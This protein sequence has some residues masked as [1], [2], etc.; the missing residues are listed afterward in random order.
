[1]KM[2]VVDRIDTAY[3]IADFLSA[4]EDRA[5]VA[6]LAGVPQRA[7]EAYDPVHEFAFA[8]P[9]YDGEVV[10][11]RSEAAA[12]EPIWFGG[13]PVQGTPLPEPLA[14][15]RDRAQDAL[16]T[17]GHTELERLAEAPFT[18]VYVDRYEAGGLFVPH[19]DRNCYGPIVVGVSAGP[20]EADLGFVHRTGELAPMSIPLA[21]RSLY[22]FCGAVRWEPWLHHVADVTANRFGITYRQP[23]VA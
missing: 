9:V 16:R 11:G 20:G 1:M 18:S 12:G 17:S 21:P 23:A 19:V 7:H 14:D 10:L 15:L 6:Y 5:L 4:D 13:R 3:H 22:A 8:H 2:Q